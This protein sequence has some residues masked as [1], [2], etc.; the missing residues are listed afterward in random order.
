MIIYDSRKMS[1]RNVK[2][3][4][5]IFFLCYFTNY[6]LLLHDFSVKYRSVFC[7]SFDITKFYEICFSF[8]LWVHMCIKRKNIHGNAMHIFPF[9]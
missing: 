4:T 9:L 1:T 5:T 3:N 2:I 7:V 6:N 8:F